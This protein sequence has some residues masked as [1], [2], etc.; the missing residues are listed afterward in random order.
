MAVDPKLIEAVR[1]FDAEIRRLQDY[2]IDMQSPGWIERLEA[3]KTDM[4]RMYEQEQ[5]VRR[6]VDAFLPALTSAYLHGGDE[7]RELLRDLLQE[8][9]RFG[10]GRSAS[11]CRNPGFRRRR[12]KCASLWRFSP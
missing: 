10:W 12:T 2:G 9:S 4:A 11:A 5:L 1:R 6:D 3:R 8:C 7:D